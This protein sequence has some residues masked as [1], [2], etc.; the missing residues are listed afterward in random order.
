MPRVTH[1]VLPGLPRHITLRGN[2]RQDK[3]F[4]DDE[5]VVYLRLLREQANKYGVRIEGYC[6]MTNHVHI[7]ATLKQED[8]L[9]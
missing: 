4:V 2:N 9:R 3:F 6:L 7:V 5:R 8:S 1:I